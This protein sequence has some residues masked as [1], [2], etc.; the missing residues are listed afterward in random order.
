MSAA[1]N[2]LGVRYKDQRRY[3]DAM[4]AHQRALALRREIGDRNW[5]A[6]SLSNIGVVLFEQ[7]K[8]NDATA[9]YRE[10]LAIARE[11]GDKRGQV[12]ALHNLAVVERETGNLRSARAAYEESIATRAEIGDK[13]GGG[14]GRIELGRVL[15][16]QGD[17]DAARTVEEEA[18][19]LF[20]ETQLRP[21][22]AQAH[23]QLGAIAVVIGD[24]PAA[25][26]HH[27]EALTI[28]R[29]MGE[30]RT[31]LESEAAL[32]ELAFHE[33]RIADA[34]REAMR[35]AGVLEAEAGPLRIAMEVLAA[36]ARLARGDIA[37]ASAAVATASR[38]AR[39]TERV[40]TRLAVTMAQA[41][42]DAARGRRN[43]A[44]ARLNELRPVL[45]RNGMVLA[46]LERRMLLLEIDRADGRANA[47]A[48]AIALQRDAETR[49]ARLIARRAQGH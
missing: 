6:V 15:L 7:D 12:R 45:E 46:D 20:V 13:R 29:D 34:E 1:L 37:G 28:R 39:G 30:T 31:V 22:E 19:R 33:G 40:D 43:D 35:L 3:A 5:T 26:R 11:I 32:A 48:D 44:R 8:L 23:Y 38:L 18:R 49:Q 4:Q 47:A 16:A 42:L 17:I 21:G 24:L 2:N 9:Y 36:R 10:S 27:Q 14:I 25:R 41:Q